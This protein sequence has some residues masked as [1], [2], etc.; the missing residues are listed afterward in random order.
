MR[1][2]RYRPID[3]CPIVDNDVFSNKT[4]QA[5]RSFREFGY[6]VQGGMDVTGE[7]T[8]MS[9]SVSYDSQEEIDNGCGVDSFTDPTV[10]FFDVAESMGVEAAENFSKQKTE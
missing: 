4:F 5:S 9:A 8:D 2:R 7:H 10:G 1:R 3:P 6:Y